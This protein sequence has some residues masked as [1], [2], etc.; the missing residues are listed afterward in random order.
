MGLKKKKGLYREGGRRG[1]DA[2]DRRNR[3]PKALVTIQIEP[4]NTE[5]ESMPL[6]K[7]KLRVYTKTSLF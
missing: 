7:M 4:R 1:T 6:T 2:E 3:I 5:E